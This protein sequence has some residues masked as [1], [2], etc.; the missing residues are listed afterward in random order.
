MLLRSLISS[1]VTKRYTERKILETHP[2]H[3]FRIIQDVDSYS[4]FLPLCSFSKVVSK[5]P[6]GR[7]F[8]GELTVGLPPFRETY[9]SH[10]VVSPEKWT[11]ETRSVRSRL[12]DEL[13]SRWK[14]KPMENFEKCQ[15]DFEIEITVSNLVIQQTLDNILEQI[16]SRQVD[17]FD[18]RC[19]DVDLP[20]DLQPR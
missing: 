6:D 2:V 3:L 10:V 12:F 4:D 18:K 14:L 11:I 8:H 7:S 9:L 16:G 15:V 20:S 1:P 13:F 19:R 17:A 5:E